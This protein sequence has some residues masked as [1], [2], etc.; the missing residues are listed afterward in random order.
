MAA[1]QLIAGVYQVC[2]LGLRVET[3]RL[4]ILV[5]VFARLWPV[6]SGFQGRIQGINSCVPAYEKLTD[7][8]SDLRPEHMPGSA[9]ARIF[10]NGRR[11]R[12]RMC[13]FPIGIP[14]RK[15]CGT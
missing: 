8:L 1:S 10:R 13:A 15:R 5:Y 11:L 12:F 4:V 3:D 9:R 7:A 6:F 14:R 2:T